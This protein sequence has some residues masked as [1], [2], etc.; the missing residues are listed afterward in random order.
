[1]HNYTYIKAIYSVYQERFKRFKKIDQLD[2]IK[3]KEFLMNFLRNS[4]IYIKK[5]L[6]EHDPIMVRKYFT[7]NDIKDIKEELKLITEQ[8][9]TFLA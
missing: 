5:N 2:D 3:D 1:M 8:P 9:K 6:V 7:E 4:Y